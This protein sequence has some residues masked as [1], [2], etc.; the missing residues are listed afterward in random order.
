M[1]NY[2]L[3]IIEDAS[4]YYIKFHFPN[5]L[6]II[7]YAQEHK[8]CVNGLTL[9][10]YNVA[11]GAVYRHLNYTT[12]IGQEIIDQLPFKS[13]AEFN[14][15]RVAVFE[16]PPGGGCGIH[17][18]GAD[19]G[20]SLN[21]ALEVHDDVCQTFWYDDDVMANMVEYG[22]PYTR[23]V[24]RN[25]RNMHRF[26]HSKSVNLQSEEAMLFN[27]N[28]FHSWTNLAS[29]NRRRVLTLRTRPANTTFETMRSKLFGC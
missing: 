5:I 28:I 11:D 6:S 9:K 3:E 24:W 4:P 15:Q 2:L 1:A 17:K 25:Y 29:G 10:E 21:I 26:R 23:N 18:D 12:D 20:M 19:T 16:T 22:M 8:S 13:A 7:D 14:P 27:T